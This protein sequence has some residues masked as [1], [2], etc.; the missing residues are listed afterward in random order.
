MIVPPACL[1]ASLLAV[2]PAPLALGATLRPWDWGVLGIYAAVLIALGVWVQVRKR[3]ATQADYFLAGRHVPVWAVAVSTL[4]T[5]QSAATFIGVPQDAYEG[6]LTYLSGFVGAIIASLIVARVFIPAYYRAGVSTPY[7]LLE[8]RF[9]HGA[10]L[11]GCW[12]YLG[13]RVLASGARVFVGAI[14]VS[15]AIFGDRDP[16][17]VAIIIVIFMAFAVLYTLWGG[18]ES[19]IWTDVLQVGV[20][21]GAACVAAYFLWR[22][23]PA[24]ASEVLDAL[25]SGAPTGG[26]G[27]GSKLQLLSFSLDPGAPFTILTILTGW[28]LLYLAAFGTDQDLVQRLLACRDARAGAR[29]TILGIAL[30]IP[31]VLLFA[32]V[33]LLLWV[34]YNRPDLMGRPTP[35]YV[36]GDTADVFL[37]WALHESPL[38]VAGLIVAGVL[39]AGPAGVNASLNSMASTLI[40]D[41]YRPRLAPNR[42]ER[43]YVTAGRWAVVLWGV[44]LGAFALACVW[45]QRASG[46]NLINFV[47]GV[48]A[49]AYAGLL[50]V[51]LTALLTKRGSTASALGAFAVGFL[52]VLA[53][54]PPVWAEWTSWTAWT[55]AHLADFRLAGAWRLVLG[56]LAAL[57]VCLLA[58][59]RA[60]RPA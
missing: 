23:I 31:A 38:G 10:R 2:A 27:G 17:H 60:K 33:G 1:P 45:W 21:I 30:N 48:M 3:Q 58:P 8:T 39:A 57:A 20:Y 14:P 50:A 35:A 28:V 54:Q 34:V 56:T 46:E 43:H 9:G 15:L 40:A 25:R 41:V 13:G 12:A 49:F 4:A 52:V 59:G 19:V 36:E 5:A 16:A 47:L 53:L 32:G 11:A 37:K 29:S 22:S 26:T 24:P 42:P 51:F 44:V 6:N 55:R 7:Q 18:L